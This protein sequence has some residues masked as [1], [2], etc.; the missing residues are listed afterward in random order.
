MVYSDKVVGTVMMISITIFLLYY[1]LWLL[2]LPFI[3]KSWELMAFFPDVYY[4]GLAVP[5]TIILISV[6]AVLSF[7]GV[8]LVLQTTR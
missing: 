2:V 5:T 8:S 6:A 3:P 7:A 4:Y 1:S